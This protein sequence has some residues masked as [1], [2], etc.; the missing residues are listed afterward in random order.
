MRQVVNMGFEA[1]RVIVWRRGGETIVEQVVSPNGTFPDESDG[2]DQ[3]PIPAGRDLCF[4]VSLGGEGS[5]CKSFCL[6]EFDKRAVR[7]RVEVDSDH[8]LPSVAPM[9][10]KGKVIPGNIDALSLKLNALPE[11]VGP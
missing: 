6:P 8:S 11:A 5:R 1:I 2:N 7:V 4:S 9:L 3:W 10:R